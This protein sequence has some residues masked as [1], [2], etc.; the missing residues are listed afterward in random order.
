MPTSELKIVINAWIKEIIEPL[1]KGDL[2][3]PLLKLISKDSND[4]IYSCIFTSFELNSSHIIAV[5]RTLKRR[6]ETA[7]PRSL[8]KCI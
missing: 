2:S 5:L 6:I 1:L 3:G 4:Q 7:L 8:W